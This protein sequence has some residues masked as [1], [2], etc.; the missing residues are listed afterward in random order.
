MQPACILAALACGLALRWALREH[1]SDDAR[2]ALLPWYAFARAHGAASLRFAFTDYPPYY[3]YL[4][5]LLTQFEGLAAPLSL[6]KA[7]SVLFELGS[8][9]VTASIVRGAGGGRWASTAGFAAAW[10][11]PTAI[12]NGAYWAQVDSLWT[13]FLL[14]AI[15][16]FMAGRNGV[17]AFGMAFAIKAQSA[18]LGPFVL[19]M[20]LRRRVSWLWLAAVPTIYMLMALP[21]IV[22]GRPLA[23]VLTIYLQQANTYNA[24]SKNAA[25]PWVFL[26]VDERLG[27]VF[28]LS[29][30]FAAGIYIARLTARLALEDRSGLVLAACASL[31]LMPLLLPKMHDRYFYAFE[32]AAIAL[33]CRDPRYVGVAVMAQANG[34][35]SYMMFDHAFPL[36]ILA[37]AALCNV[38]LAA[39][40]VA[41][42]ARPVGRGGAPLAWLAAFVV[43]AAALITDLMT[44]RPGQAAG[45]WYPLAAGAYAVTGALLIWRTRYGGSANTPV[46]QPA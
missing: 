1:V 13:F 26:A 39:L 42:M 24:L 5:L 35:L 18:F 16:L 6:L 33:A 11:A 8:A 21:V 27:V 25:N 28:G 17:P 29:I 12:L 37:P 22:A 15:R 20:I 43:A 38:A 3:S 7:A 30:A 46:K 10:L 41:D 4:L 44:A 32:I 31:L 36:T 19:G 14:V 40:L 9:V 2:E 34:L 45:G 23:D